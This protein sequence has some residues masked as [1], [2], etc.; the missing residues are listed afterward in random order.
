MYCVLK[1]YIFII[2][3]VSKWSSFLQSNSIYTSVYMQLYIL[4]NYIRT[5]EYFGASLIGFSTRLIWLRASRCYTYIIS[6]YMQNLEDK[7]WRSKHLFCTQ[8]K[9]IEFAKS[10]YI[11]KQ[12]Y[13]PLKCPGYEFVI[14]KVKCHSLQVYLHHEHYTHIWIFWCFSYWIQYP[15]DLIESFTLLHLYIPLEKNVA[16]NC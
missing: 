5:Y 13:L 10:I 9:A 11:R 15:A 3:I 2:S 12:R 7:R 6:P 16:Y 14:K 8:H 1:R 4:H